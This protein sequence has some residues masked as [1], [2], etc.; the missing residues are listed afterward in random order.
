MAHTGYTKLNDLRALVQAH[1]LLWTVTLSV[2]LEEDAA[3]LAFM[4]G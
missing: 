1:L 2:I 4:L 3:M